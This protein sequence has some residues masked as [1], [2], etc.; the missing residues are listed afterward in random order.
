MTR[1][2]TRF[3]TRQPMT[4]SIFRTNPFYRVLRAFGMQDISVPDPA[5]DRAYIVRTNHLSATQSLLMDRTL[6]RALRALRK[7]RLEVVRE[8]RRLRF[9]DGSELRWVVGKLEKDED[10]ENALAL[11]RATIDGLFRLGMARVPMPVDEWG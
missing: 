4:L 3:R 8:R 5:L 6:T 11:M 1:M 10:L 9:T 7:G 2:R